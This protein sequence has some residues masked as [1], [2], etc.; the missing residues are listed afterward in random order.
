MLYRDLVD[1][2]GATFEKRAR[3]YDEEALFVDQNYKELKKYRFFSLLV[4]RELGGP[5][6]AFAEVSFLLRKLACYCPST[7]LALSM[8]QHLVAAAVWTC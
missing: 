7:A 8:H 2:L 4:P 3:A 6:L 5:G 1:Q